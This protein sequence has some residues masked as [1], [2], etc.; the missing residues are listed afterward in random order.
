MSA[1]RFHCIFCGA[2]HTAN[3]SREERLFECHECHHVVP[4]PALADVADGPAM[5]AFPDGVLTLEMK[6]LCTKCG[7]KL[8]VDARWEGRSVH[9]P[10][11]QSATEIPRWSLRREPAPGVVLTAEEVA[12]LSAESAPQPA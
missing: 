2:K 10:E 9:C 5:S 6:F 11:C 1:I 7:L 4:V 3:G 12:F 8:Q